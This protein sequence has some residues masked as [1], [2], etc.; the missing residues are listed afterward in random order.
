MRYTRFGRLNPMIWALW[1]MASCVHPA[2]KKV[3]VQL[4]EPLL[5]KC[6][7]YASVK[8]CVSEAGEIS[9]AVANL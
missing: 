3:A 5:A 9:M 8:R 4:A 6:C 2:A 7:I 1:S